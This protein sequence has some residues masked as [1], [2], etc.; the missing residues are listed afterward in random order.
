[1]LQARRVRRPQGDRQSRRAD[2]PP[3][4][5]VAAP[6]QSARRSRRKDGA[7]LRVTNGGLMD[8][9]SDALANRC[10]FRTAN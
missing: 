6:D 9:T 3:R 4:T 7:R 1:M 8:F 5:A 10:T 2:V